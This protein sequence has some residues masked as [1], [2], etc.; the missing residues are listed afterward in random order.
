[1]MARK[2]STKDT[3]TRRRVEAILVVL[4]VLLGPSSALGADVYLPGEARI[5]GVGETADVLLRMDSLV[6]EDVAAGLVV[7]GYDAA[8]V[9]ATELDLTGLPGT[10]TADSSLGQ[11]VWLPS[12]CTRQ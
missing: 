11:C 10:C 2:F 7:I 4:C 1:M 9:T 3:P 12:N 5:A 8:K 6:A